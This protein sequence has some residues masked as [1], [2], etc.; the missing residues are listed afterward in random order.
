MSEYGFWDNALSYSDEEYS[1]EQMV[2]LDGELL[3][4]CDLMLTVLGEG[5]G[6]ECPEGARTQ[7]QRY[8]RRA[9]SN[10]NRI[11]GMPD[12]IP[13]VLDLEIKDELKEEV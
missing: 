5:A 13:W 2:D 12:E 4:L 3:M 9:I 10:R 7:G 8:I 1:N 6:F 11:L